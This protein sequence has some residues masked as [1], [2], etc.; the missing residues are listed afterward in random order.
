M[1]TQPK[2]QSMASVGFANQV[3]ATLLAATMPF[4]VGMG[5]A[6]ADPARP[7][8]S[9]TPPPA[10]APDVADPSPATATTNAAPAHKMFIRE[11]RVTGSK[12][13]T[14]VEI[15]DTV[16]PFLGPDRTVDGADS[17]VEKARAA[18]E[19][20]YHNKGYNTVQVQLPK[21]DGR[22]GVVF[23]EV[24][25]NKVGRLRVKGSRYFSLDA[26]RKSLPAIAPGTVP[27][28][29]ELTQQMIGVNQWPDRRVT[30]GPDGLRPGVEPGTVDID[31]TVKDTPPL[32]GSLELNNRYSPDTTPLRL[33]GGISY[34]NLWQLG[35]AAGFSF[36]ISP[37]DLSQVK[38]YSAYYLARLPNVDWL[39][40]TLQATD[41]DSNVSTLSDTAVAGRGQ[42]VGFRAGI[43]LPPLKNYVHSL[44][45]GIDYKHYDQATTLGAGT[46][47]AATTDAPVTY[48]PI[49]LVYSG[50]WLGKDGHNSTTID[51]GVYFSFRGTGSADAEFDTL[52]YLA[53]GNFIYF[54]G[55]L[56]HEQELPLGFQVFG[57]VQG[58]ISDQPL[59]S[60]EQF[61][62]GGLSSVRGYLEGEVPGDNAVA[63]SFEL[64][65]PSLLNW[66]SDK[67]GDWRVYGFFDTAYVNINSPLP[68]QQA[69]WTLASVGG[70]SR[71]NLFDHLHGSFDAGLPL[72]TETSTIAHHWLL[73]FRVWGDF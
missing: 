70:G 43:T 62:A 48:Y 46:I 6:K 33:N 49:S 28:F 32:H 69:Y 72:T 10:A 71:I 57:K 67:G 34:S 73:T 15:G 50:T 31:L 3:L 45:F 23:L 27:N 41:Q 65:S 36:Q 58:Q 37:E 22:G 55:D 25:E 61:A 11:Y 1:G 59:I 12:I 8:R 20:A 35:H 64:R 47:G 19:A 42:T 40:L 14:A 39:T 54:K 30:V 7:A 24:V 21:Q 66:V 38:V 9:V 18:L 52:R 17:D 2:F 44:T 16:Y 63:A 51:A 68:E 56:A 29:N 60:N 13:L 4:W 26:I 53:Q 5:V